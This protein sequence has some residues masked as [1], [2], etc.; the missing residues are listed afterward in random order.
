[1]EQQNNEC[2]LSDVTIGAFPSNV[3]NIFS[4]LDT[5]LDETN[6]VSLL[7]FVMGFSHYYM[8]FRLMHD[9]IH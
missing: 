8:S 6:S 7:V 4:D 9:N 3:L 5:W 1:M 2:K